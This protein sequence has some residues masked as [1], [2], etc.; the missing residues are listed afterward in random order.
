V[1]LQIVVD[2]QFLAADAQVIV[3]QI[4]SGEQHRNQYDNQ[5]FQLSG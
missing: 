2:G 5:S 1:Q 3:Y 4:A